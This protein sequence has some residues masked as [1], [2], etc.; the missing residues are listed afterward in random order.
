MPGSYLARLTVLFASVWLWV[1]AGTASAQGFDP[2]GRL[3]AEV[4]IEGL[5]DVSEELVR[6][7]LRSAAGQPYDGEVISA[8]IRR[9]EMLGRFGPPIESAVQDMGDGTLVVIFRVNEEPALAGISFSGNKAFLATQLLSRVVLRSGDPIDQSL[10]E[11]G[12]RAIEQAYEDKGYFATSVSFDEEA[13]ADRRELIYRIVEGPKV[14]IL[15]IR[16]EGNEVFRDEALEDRIQSEEAYV[17][18]FPGHLNRSLLDFDAASIRRYYQDAGYLEADVGRTIALSPNMRD[19]IVT[20]QI[21]EGPRYLVDDIAVR[22]S[23]DGQPTDRHLFQPRQI[24]IL[25]AVQRG[26]VFSDQR[27]SDTAESIRVWYGRLGYINVNVDIRRVFDREN[28]RV[29]VEI[30]IDEGSGP[31]YAGAITVIGNSRTKIEEVLHRINGIEPGRPIDYAGLQ[32][33][34]QL[35]RESTLFTGGTVTLLGDPTDPVRDVLIEINER[36]TGSFNFFVGVNSDLGVNGGISVTQRNFDITDW[37]ESFD[38][39]LG[40]KAFL[41]GGQTFNLTLSPG[42]ENSLYEIGFR[43][44]YLFESD[45]FFSFNARFSQSVREKFDE[46]RSGVRLGLGR[47]LGDVWTGS[48]NL[49]FEQ[50]DI[51]AIEPDAPVDVFAVGGDSTLSAVGVSLTRSTTDS[52]IM[53]SR[54]SRLV[55]NLDQY[56]ALGGD[57]DFTKVN[58]AYNHFWTLDEDFLGRKSILSF[59][60]QM[61]YIFEDNEDIPLFERFYAG[62]RNFRGFDHRGAGP[63]GVRMD[64]MTLGDDPVGGRF[65]FITRLEYEVPLYE[66]TVRWAVFTDQGTVQDDFGFDEWRVSIGTGFRFVIP[67]FGQAPVALDFAVPIVHEDGDETEF[68]SFSIDLPFN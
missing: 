8:D 2:E 68:F 32:L 62:G 36:N 44:P 13:L 16:F 54:G 53:P 33:T 18:F 58:V 50:I 61:G 11:R 3:I 67:F 47:R 14:R 45:Y 65:R 60:A 5:V 22:F 30:N 51:D 17:L 6:N 49:R 63:R 40:N 64:T 56:G 27:I 37:P 66:E 29:D 42:N 57:Y 24:E 52:N 7:A 28:A 35:V 25:A 4:R 43:E 34:R 31:T 21:K 38:E 59:S 20:F 41:G 10:I 1:G 39:F 26:G 19:A 9:L 15:E 12:A 23:R 46:G 55:V 48:L